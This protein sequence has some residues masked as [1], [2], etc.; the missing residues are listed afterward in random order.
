MLKIQKNTC[1]INEDFINHICIDEYSSTP[2]YK[3]LIN[4]I[5]YAIETAKIRKN[6]MLPSI[7]ELSFVLD[8]SRDTAE[9][10]YRHLRKLGVIDSIPGKGYFVIHTDYS[11]KLK[12]CLLF[13]KLSTHKKIVYDSFTKAIGEDA[14]ID[15]YVYNNDF[16]L[17]KSILNNKKDGYTHYVIIPHFTEG[18]EKAQ[19][20]INT[21]PREKLVILD[22]LLPGITDPYTAVYENFSQDIYLALEQ[23][24]IPLKKYNTIKIIF[25]KN[26]YYPKEILNGFYR[27]CQQYCFC[28]KI[29][30]HIKEEE[31]NSGEVYINLM[32]DDLVLL[33]KRVIAMGLEVGKDVG[34]ISYNETPLKAIILNGITPIS[35]DFTILGTQAAACIL[36]NITDKIHVPFYLNLRQSL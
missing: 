30:H 7:N 20:L 8:I 5:I 9:K 15:L 34:I 32:E 19:L 13:N 33:I 22:K 31:I 3:Q 11:R 26:S 12:I 23:A 25:P 16:S 18:D 10:G 4:A 35:T 14:A 2:K 17:F 29:V 28:H 24:L 1:S 6:D 36:N 21:I 27:F